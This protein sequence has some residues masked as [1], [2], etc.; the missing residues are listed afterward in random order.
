MD[1]LVCAKEFAQ[2]GPGIGVPKPRKP[3]SGGIKRNFVERESRNS[4][5][6]LC[7]SGRRG[8]SGERVDPATVRRQAGPSRVEAEAALSDA[9]PAA[10]L[11]VGEIDP[12]GRARRAG[13]VGPRAG[14][15]GAARAPASMRRKNVPGEVT[16]AAPIAICIAH[17]WSWATV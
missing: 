8:R 7:L 3:E 16:S 9:G 12:P 13:K 2:R 17:C 6:S 15:F 11:G 10:G 14:A 1:E 4:I 5:D